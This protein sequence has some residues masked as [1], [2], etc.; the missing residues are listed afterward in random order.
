MFKEMVP[1]DVAGV[2]RD[3]NLRTSRYII[4]SDQGD[5]MVASETHLDGVQ[6]LLTIPKALHCSMLQ[7]PML[8]DRAGD[9]LAQTLIRE[10]TDHRYGRCRSGPISPG[11]RRASP[12]TILMTPRRTSVLHT[13]I[14]REGNPVLSNFDHTITGA[15]E[16]H[17]S[18]SRPV[19]PL[20]DA[21]RI[22][23]GRLT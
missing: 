11:T 2:L 12:S 22:R 6:H 20:P 1:E 5:A 15:H 8:L 9:S 14:S 3:T 16:L 4:F 23:P 21:G 17:S 18:L 10:R 19:F 7:R 13:V